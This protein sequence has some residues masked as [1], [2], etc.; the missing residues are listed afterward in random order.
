[1]RWSTTASNASLNPRTVTCAS[2]K[3]ARSKR[4]STGVA[5]WRSRRRAAGSE[6]GDQHDRSYEASPSCSRGG[7]TATHGAPDS[8][9][10]G[11]RCPLGPVP[12]GLAP[13]GCLERRNPGCGAEICGRDGSPGAPV[14]LVAGGVR[15]ARCGPTARL[16][17]RPG[18]SLNAS[19]KP[20][21][22]VVGGA[23]P[24]H[25]PLQVPLRGTRGPDG[26]PRRA[27][28][29]SP[30]LN[31]PSRS[32]A[33]GPMGASGR[34]PAPWHQGAHRGRR[35]PGRRPRHHHPTQDNRP[36][37]R[38]PSASIR[39]PN[40]APGGRPNRSG[41]VSQQRVN[42]RTLPLCVLTLA[43]ATRAL[44]PLLSAPFERSI[45]EGSAP[46]QSVEP[47]LGRLDGASPPPSARPE[48]C[49]RPSMS[50]AGCTRGTTGGPSRPRYIQQCARWIL[51]G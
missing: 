35:A 43:P 23:S 18:A 17:G 29:H 41:S 10:G 7:E 50:S 2:L 37:A 45:P 14:A 16:E 19:L 6:P 26:P 33:P 24:G 27:N 13:P 8:A 4:T 28:R 22:G 40:R 30:V 32:R 31:G 25:A 1:M 46:T 47:T 38:L 15:P 9:P 20:G 42:T 51:V 34:S 21:L 49:S 39:H 44:W 11:R 5:G 48:V 12:A 36:D 3:P